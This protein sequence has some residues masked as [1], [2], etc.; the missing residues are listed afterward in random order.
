MLGTELCASFILS[1]C[2]AVDVHSSSYVFWNASYSKACSC[3]KQLQVRINNISH[4]NRL[5]IPRLEG[6]GLSR[7]GNARRISDAACDAGAHAATH[8]RAPAVGRVGCW[9]AEKNP[10]QGE[11]GSPVVAFCSARLMTEEYS[12]TVVTLLLPVVIKFNQLSSKMT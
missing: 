9:V 6:L 3:G 10:K 2:S 7:R 11:H 4:K 12:P 8:P 1:P 5:A